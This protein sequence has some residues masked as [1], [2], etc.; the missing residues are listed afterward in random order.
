MINTI[1]MFLIGFGILVAAS[2][3]HI[4]VISDTIFNSSTKAVEFTFGLAGMIALWSGILK[5][6]ETAGITEWIAKIF[7]PI[8]AL[9]FPSLKTAQSALG[10]ISMTV[11]ANM[12]GLGNVATPIGLKTM[13]ELQG[14]NQTPNQASPEICTFMTLV[15]GGLSLIPSTLIAIRSQAGSSQPALVLG[16]VLI[17]TLIA[18]SAGLLFNHLALRLDDWYHRKEH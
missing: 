12:L 4:G 13:A 9:L 1:W 10:L 16:P 3:G 2:T 18:T 5:V 8:L 17:I 14:H 6:A 7:Q 15:F 11:A